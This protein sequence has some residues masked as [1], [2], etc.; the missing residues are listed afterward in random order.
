MNIVSSAIFWLNAF[1]PS[2]HVAGLSDTKSPGQL[3][4]GTV[5]EYK[6]FCRLQPGE[7]VQVHQEDEPRNTMNIDLNVGVIVQWTQYN[8]SREAISL[9]YYWQYKSSG[10]HIGPLLILMRM[11]LKDTK[12]LTPKV[13]QKT[14]FLSILIINPS[15]PPIMVS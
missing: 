13:V 4:I 15:H 5:V 9:K 3:F 2:T 14:W 7:Y 6:K 8:T 10:G 11:A 12:I 1:P